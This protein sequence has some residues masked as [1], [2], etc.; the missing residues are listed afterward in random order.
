MSWETA[1]LSPSATRTRRGAA[2]DIDQS[3]DVRR[4]RRK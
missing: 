4:D 1:V 3:M 2:V